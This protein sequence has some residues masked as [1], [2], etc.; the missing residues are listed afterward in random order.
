M[1]RSAQDGEWSSPHY[2]GEGV[3]P[4]APRCVRA[5]RWGRASSNSGRPGIVQGA[6]M[7]GIVR[8]SQ[9]KG[10]ATGNAKPGLKPPG[11]I[12]ADISVSEVPADAVPGVG[13]GHGTLERSRNKRLRIV[14]GEWR[15]RSRPKGRSE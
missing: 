11:G 4:V 3:L 1:N 13:S 9:T 5:T 14:T 10:R 2:G 6:G 8:H 12:G 15:R 7:A